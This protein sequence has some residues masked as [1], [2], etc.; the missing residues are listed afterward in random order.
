MN[1]TRGQHKRVSMGGERS[2]PSVGEGVVTGVVEV[3]S[4]RHGDSSLG[5]EG[6]PS[7]RRVAEHKKSKVQRLGGKEDEQQP[8][9]EGTW[10]T[11]G[12]LMELFARVVT[13]RTI[14]ESKAKGGI[15]TW[16]SK[17]AGVALHGQTDV[18]DGRNRKRKPGRVLQARARHTMGAARGP[19]RGTTDSFRTV[20][21]NIMTEHGCTHQPKKKL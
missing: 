4:G 18:A 2:Q 6:S 13:A 19:G 10:G 7:R 5:D 20:K 1:E 3:E 16:A 17:A 9:A 12:D 11:P 21:R 8:D 15:A 14:R